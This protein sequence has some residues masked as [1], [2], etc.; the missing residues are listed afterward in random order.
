[1]THAANLFRK[2]WKQ[3]AKRTVRLSFD[4]PFLLT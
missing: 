2:L 1:M 3:L 4:F